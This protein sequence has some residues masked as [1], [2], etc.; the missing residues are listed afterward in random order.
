MTQASLN[1]SSRRRGTSGNT[2]TSTPNVSTNAGIFFN[3]KIEG[4]HGGVPGIV[5]NEQSSPRVQ[6]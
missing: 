2:N 4:G 6:A 3:G 1:V 5:V